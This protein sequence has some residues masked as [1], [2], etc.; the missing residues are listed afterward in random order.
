MCF[1]FSF[2]LVPIKISLEFRT[3]L[4]NLFQKKPE[5]P[6]FSAQIPKSMGIK[7]NIFVRERSE[8]CLSLPVT[9]LD[10]GGKGVLLTGHLRA[11]P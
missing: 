11:S 8:L 1:F 5:D 10:L 2:T 7:L 4:L 6:R 3:D 9:Y